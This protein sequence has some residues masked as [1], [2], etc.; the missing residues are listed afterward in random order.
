MPPKLNAASIRI[1]VVRRFRCER[2]H[3]DDDERVV[4]PRIR[5]FDDVRGTKEA[6]NTLLAQLSNERESV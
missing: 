1:N 3:R 4:Q 5:N 6:S 2:T